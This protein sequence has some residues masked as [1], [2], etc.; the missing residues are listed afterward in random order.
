MGE[1]FFTR[2]LGNHVLEEKTQPCKESLLTKVMG[3]IATVGGEREENRGRVAR[4]RE[5]AGGSRNDDY[6]S[7]C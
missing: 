3:R 5:P 2:A 4:A 6:L 7:Q 1:P